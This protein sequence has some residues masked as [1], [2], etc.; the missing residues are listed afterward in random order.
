MNRSSEELEY[1]VRIIATHAVERDKI[2]PDTS[3]GLCGRVVTRSEKRQQQAKL[4]VKYLQDF[5]SIREV[6]S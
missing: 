2:V 1:Y 3:T 4:D 6:S 5:I